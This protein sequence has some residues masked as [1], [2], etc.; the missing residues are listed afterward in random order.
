MLRVQEVCKEKGVTM[1]ELAARLG[2][3]YQALY[4]SVSGNP[5]IGKVKE[6]AKALGVDYIEL[7]EPKKEV[8]IYIEYQGKT[9]RISESDLI[10]LFNEK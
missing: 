4:S 1:Q 3:S 5:T 8:T 9:K 7:L 2:V 10:K 6:Y